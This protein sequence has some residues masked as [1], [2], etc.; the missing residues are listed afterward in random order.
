MIAV[1]D[2]YEALHD[3]PTSCLPHCWSSSVG[4]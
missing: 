1:G 4:Q 3:A 2:E